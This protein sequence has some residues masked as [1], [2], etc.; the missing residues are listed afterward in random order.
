MARTESSMVELGSPA[1]DF[2][3]P[4]A[5]PD[6][7]NLEKRTRNITDYGDAEALVVVFWCNHCPFVQHIEPAFVKLAAEYQEQGVA[8]VAICSNNEVTHPQ[9]SFENMGDRAEEIG[10]TF[11]Y[12]R[13][14]TQQV[15][16]DYGAVCTPDFF[17][18]NNEREL[19]YRGRFDGSTPSKGLATGKDL[20]KA[21]DELLEEGEVSHLQK[22]SLGC[23]IKWKEGNQPA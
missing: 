1:A 2:D 3:L 15:A 23:N 5:N 7:D 6:V 17:V 18:Y 4:I 10:Y 13:D 8:F 14:D 16:Q 11:P 9:D 20:R 12:L 21:L 22:P 19:V